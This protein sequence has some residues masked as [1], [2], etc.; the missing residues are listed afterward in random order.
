MF[1]S[2]VMS[3]LELLDEN[4]LRLANIESI[5]DSE[6]HEGKEEEG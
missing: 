1:A 3:F 2:I 6:I 5:N 4:R